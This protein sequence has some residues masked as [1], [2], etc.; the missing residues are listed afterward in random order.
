MGESQANDGSGNSSQTVESPKPGTPISNT[1]KR[2]RNDSDYHEHSKKVSRQHP[3][4]QRGV[5]E[6]NYNAKHAFIRKL[7]DEE[8]IRI[9][10]RNHN[11]YHPLH[12]EEEEG[13]EKL[14]DKLKVTKYFFSKNNSNGS[15]K[16]PFMTF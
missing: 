4:Q 2:K 10:G 9:L 6:D 1:P 14:V 8:W 12:A 13:W 5:P 15:I 3:N 11:L 16:K 7:H